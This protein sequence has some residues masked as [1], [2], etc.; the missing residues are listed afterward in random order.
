MC[1]EC[2][3]GNTCSELWTWEAEDNANDSSLLYPSRN[4]EDEESL[5]HAMPN[6]E[7]RHLRKG[8]EKK[9][10]KKRVAFPFDIDFDYLS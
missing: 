7:D 10:N 2:S 5:F 4:K 8:G 9:W 1:F 6:G 3:T